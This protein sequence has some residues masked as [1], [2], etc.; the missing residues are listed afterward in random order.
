[1][2]VN[3]HRCANI[4]MAQKF[5]LHLEIDTERVKQR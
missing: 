1:M 3:V 5:L 4:R 2:R